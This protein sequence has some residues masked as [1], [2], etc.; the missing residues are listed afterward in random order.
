MNGHLEVNKLISIE[1]HGFVA[2][3]A[4]VTNLLECQ[5]LTTIALHE[6]KELDVLYTDFMKAFDKVSHRKLIH[7]LKA[8]GFGEKLTNW[9]GSFLIG[10]KQRVVLGE[11]SSNWCNVDSGVPQGSVL[12]PLLFV[13]YIN[14]LPDYLT[15]RLKLYADDGKLI[16][17]LGTDRDND[18]MQA[19][20]NRIIEWCETWS[21]ELSPE[22]CKIMHL[23]NQKDPKDYLIAGRK[24]GTTDCERDLGVLVSSDGTWHEQVCSAA[25]KAN[26]VLGLMKSTFSCW[27]DD[28]ARIIYPTFIRPHLEFASSVWNPHLKYDSNTLE[29]VQRRAT[30]T[31]ESYHLPYKER[32]ERL[33]LTNLSFRRERGDFIQIYKIVHGLEKVN[34]SD[35]N[36]ILR[37]NQC[38]T[39]RRHHFQLSREYTRG[40]E[41][42]TNILLNRMATPWNNLPKEIVLAPSVN[43][44]KSRLDSHLGKIRG[45]TRIY[46]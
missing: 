39:G 9:V 21:M 38:R 25:S 37:P 40:N 44:F 15:H 16:V 33:G 31:R 14:D 35:K 32:L 43:S 28:I 30:L 34:W 5:D 20:I 2:S 46:T 6:H 10:R 19:D 11:T 45:K 24:L 1:Q 7:K 3:K 8:Y 12:G 26:R 29:S 42:R 18:D 41:P 4:C 13:I 36:K 23:G 27:S 17:E 22:K